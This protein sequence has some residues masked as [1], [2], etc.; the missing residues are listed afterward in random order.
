MKT[1]VT[2][3]AVAMTKVGFFLIVT[4]S[5]VELFF[6]SDDDDGGVLLGNGDEDGVTLH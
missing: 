2:M 6:G 4:M 3:M 5:M 1:A